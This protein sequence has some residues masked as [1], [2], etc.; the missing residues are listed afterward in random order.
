MLSEWVGNTYIHKLFPEMFGSKNLAQNVLANY[1]HVRSSGIGQ[2]GPLEP[3][4][5]KH[6]RPLEKQLRSQSDRLPD[7]ALT[8]LTSTNMLN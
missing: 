5:E 2:V 1:Y 6:A 4:C 7:V 3:N 8:G